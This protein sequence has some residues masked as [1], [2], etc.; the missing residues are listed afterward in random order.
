MNDV[1]YLLRIE[2]EDNA[3]YIYIK[4]LERF[5]NTHTCSQLTGTKICPFCQKNV[6]EKEHKTHLAQ[7]FKF[8][9]EGTIIKLPE[10]NDKGKIPSMKFTN[11]KNKLERPYIVYAD[12]ES[13][14][15]KTDHKKNIHEHVPNSCSFYFVCI[16]D[17]TQNVFWNDVSINCVENMIKELN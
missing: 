13:T 5:F 8:A 2:N 14:L 9:K 6:K 4:H 3:H 1:I 7:C 17:S 10:P 15:V 16:Y 11:F 12:M